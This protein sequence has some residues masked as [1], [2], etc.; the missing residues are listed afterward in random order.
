MEKLNEIYQIVIKNT[1]LDYSQN[2]LSAEE[3]DSLKKV[4]L[5]EFGY[6]LDEGYLSFLKQINGFSLNGWRFYG[7]IA[8]EKQYIGSILEEN[9]FW[10]DEISLPNE[11]FVVADMDSNVYCYDFSTKKF[12]T[13][14]KWTTNVEKVFNS[15]QDMM[16]EVIRI[17][18]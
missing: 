14:S 18:V 10:H 11:L 13:A 16:E 5:I 1:Y 8:V 17:C 9:K 6:E 3:I 4:C 2:K 7:T 15:F 12:C